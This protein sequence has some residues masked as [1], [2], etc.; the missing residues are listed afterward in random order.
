MVRKNLSCALLIVWAAVF[1]WISLSTR[2][3]AVSAD[4]TH[5]GQQAQ[6]GAGAAQE[7][8]A[9]EQFKNIQVLKDIPASQLIES[10]QFI[11]AA[12]GVACDFCHVNPFSEDTKK[13]KQTARKML[14]MV[15]AIN[16]QNFN[17]RSE[18]NCATCHQGHNDPKSYPPLAAGFTDVVPGKA[19]G[20]L[21]TAD[22]ILDKYTEALGGKAAID[23]LTSRES[24]GTI[25]VPDRG[26]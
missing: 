9:G 21:P 25:E 16:D 10:M 26:S 11:S 24:K 19:E 1:G 6:P 23:K 17:G 3:G 22:Q 12:L 14:L 4:S 13:E 18:V 2:T 15:K 7:K 8:T 20:Q 5:P